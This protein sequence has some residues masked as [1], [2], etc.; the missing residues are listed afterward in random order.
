MRLRSSLIKSDRWGK[1]FTEG[2]VPCP[3][4]VVWFASRFSHFSHRL[5]FTY[6]RKHLNLLP[7]VR[8]TALSAAEAQVFLYRPPSNPRLLA[9]L[10]KS[11]NVVSWSLVASSS[12]LLYPPTKISSATT[13]VPER[14]S[15]TS[16]IQFCTE[17]C[18]ELNKYEMAV[19]AFFTFQRVCGTSSALTIRHPGVRVAKP[20]VDVHL[21]E[22]FRSMQSWDNV[23]VGRGI[24]LDE[25]LWLFRS[26][27]SMHSLS[28]PLGFT[29]ST[30]ATFSM[31]LK[32]FKL[33]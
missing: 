19:R 7:C 20:V 28:H 24:F 4:S 32:W 16:R 10:Q 30:N 2:I 27:G 8:W 17:I 23:F 22:K 9:A 3:E 26:R 21:W 11:T 29:T 14:P 13:S 15:I 18:Q 6:T 33:F 5:Y 25:S 31:I 1:N 12:F